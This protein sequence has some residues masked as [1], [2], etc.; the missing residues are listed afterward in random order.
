[1][2]QSQQMQD[3]RVQI[4]QMDPIDRRFITDL[5]GFSEAR[6]TSDPTTR[7]PCS[8]AMRVMVPSRLA[9]ELGDRQ[10]TKL[11]APDDQGVFKHPAL[12]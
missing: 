4:V 3:R 6:S 8:K 9:P 5:V 11:T 12:S 1:M 10:S 2:I 7:H